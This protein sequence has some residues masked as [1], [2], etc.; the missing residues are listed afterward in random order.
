LWSFWDNLL[1]ITFLQDRPEKSFTALTTIFTN[2]DLLTYPL[3]RMGISAVVAFCHFSSI[4][5]KFLYILCFLANSRKQI[6]WILVKLSKDKHKRINVNRLSHLVLFIVESV[7][8]RIEIIALSRHKKSASAW[9]FGFK[10]GLEE[11]QNKEEVYWPQ[12]CCIFNLSNTKKYKLL[13]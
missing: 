5:N 10:I 6:L 11:L 4:S 7:A 8:S 9:Q 3:D 13:K 12:N 1:A 2:R